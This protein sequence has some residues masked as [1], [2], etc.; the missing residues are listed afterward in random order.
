MLA[1]G[2]FGK[3]LPECYDWFV[4]CVKKHKVQVCMGDFNMCMFDLVQQCRSRGLTIDA[5]AWAPSKTAGGA[6]TADSMAIM[7][8]GMPGEYRPAKGPGVLHEG[9]GGFLAHHKND[10]FF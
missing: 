3:K 9:N 4:D 5:G 1:N 8:V 7:V 2:D 6:P 10:E